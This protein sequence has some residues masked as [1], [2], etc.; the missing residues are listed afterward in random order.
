MV[1]FLS[2]KCALEPVPRPLYRVRAVRML[3]L[4][5]IMCRP[6]VW[7]LT[8]DVTRKR[9]KDTVWDWKRE[10]ISLEIEQAQFE[11]EIASRIEAQ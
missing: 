9:Q 5:P 4:S 8:F 11:E 6:Q 3:P 1:I 2:V 10:L 7:R